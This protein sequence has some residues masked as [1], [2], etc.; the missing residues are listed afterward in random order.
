MFI[1][2]TETTGT[3]VLLQS[4]WTIMPLHVAVLQV[5]PPERVVNL[6]WVIPE[7][8]GGIGDF[9]LVGPSTRRTIDPQLH[10]ALLDESLRE[11]DQIWRVLAER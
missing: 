3:S 2:Q 6:V 7:E 8:L 11:Y 5:A 9:Q 4:G 1:Q 10:Q